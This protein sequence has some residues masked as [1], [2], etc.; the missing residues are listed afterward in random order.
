MPAYHPHEI[1]KSIAEHLD[2][3]S[4]TDCLEEI[5]ELPPTVGEG[6]A[7]GFNFSDGVGLLVLDF[8]LK[9]DWTLIFENDH[10]GPLQF[11]FT[12]QGKVRHF[13]NNRNIQYELAPLF[14]TITCNPSGSMQ[15][16]QFPSNTKILFTCLMID[17][18]KYF[19]KIDC[20]LKEM[21]EKLASIFKDTEARKP[22]FYQS[23]YSITSAECIQIITNNRRK[24]LVRCAYLE[25]KA[26][27]LLSR[28]AK[29]FQDDLRTPGRQVTLRKFDVEKIKEAKNILIADLQNPPTIELLSKQ[30]GIN[31][32]KLKTGF[33]KVF[34][35]TIYNY[36][37]DERL[38]LA[39]LIL[40]ENTMS[41]KETARAVGYANQSHFAKRF[42]EKYGVLPK[43]YIKNIRAKIY[44]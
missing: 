23:H 33:K 39:R 26:L 19:E 16:F 28:Q 25:G 21:P 36:L 40:L 7:V 22:F 12:T 38:E 35:K 8:I 15:Y 3:S 24:G 9:E 2:V 43:D 37:R 27:E 34:D 44:D 41:I 18:A 11:N 4:R 5:L 17:R 1:I 30:V 6:R 42:K 13:F 14:G 31:R 10:P 29:Q 32:Q 20:V